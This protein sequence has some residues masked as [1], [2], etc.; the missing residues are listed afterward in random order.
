[1]R[2]TFDARNDE[3]SKKAESVSQTV[4]DVHNYGKS[5]TVVPGINGSEKRTR[6][7]KVENGKE[8]KR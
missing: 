1:L 6:G 5:G 3:A 4:A 8:T 2:D 7:K